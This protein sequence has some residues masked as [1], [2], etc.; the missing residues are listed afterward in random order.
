M[1]SDGT[2]GRNGRR[3]W[4]TTLLGVLTVGMGGCISPLEEPVPDDIVVPPPPTDIDGQWLELAGDNMGGQNLAGANLAGSNLA[5][6]N[7]AGVNLGGTNLASTNLASTNLAGT[8]I[9]GNNLA[10]NNLAGT[11]LASTNLAGTNLAGTNMSARTLGSSTLNGS[12]SSG[13][14]LAGNSISGTT[15]NATTLTST[16]TGRNI[17]KLG[18]AT[19]MLYSG[20]DVWSPKSA[21]CIVLGI[22][23]TAFP[24]LLAQQT[25]NAK[26]NVA[27]GMLPWGFSTKA[28]ATMALRA[29]EAIVWGDR[30]YCVFVM[31]TPM[32]ATWPGVAGFI[33][34]VFRW[35]APPSQA[36]EISG[37]EASAAADPGVSTGILGFSGMM[38]AGAQ[39]RAGTLSETAFVAGELAFAAATTNNQSVLVDFSAWV[40]KKDKNPLVLGNVQ[41]SSKPSYAE[42]LYI[43]L[44]NGDGTV[45][46]ILDDAAAKAA[47]MPTGMIDS[48]VDLNAAYLAYKDG[49]GSKPIPRRCGG[50]L[51]LN[52][53]FGEPVPPGK[54]DDG[55]AWAP[56][57]CM[58]NADDWSSVAGTTAPMN[59]YMLLNKPGQSYQRAPMV[60]GSCGTL[61]SVLSETYVHMWDRNYDLSGPCA[62]ESDAA[63]C[64]R[65]GKNCGQVTDADNCG[66]MRTV[67]NC[68]SCASPEVCGGSGQPNVCARKSTSYEGEAPGN[69]FGGQAIGSTCAEAFSKFG[70]GSSAEA[71]DGSCSGGSKVRFIGNS[72]SNYVTVN[73]VYAPVA[74]SY[75]MTVYA[76]SADTRNFYIS[77][78]GG[79][80][81]T[82]TMQS[83]GWTVQVSGSTTVTLRAGNN[84][85]KFYNNSTWAPDLDRIVVYEAGSAPPPTSPPPPTS[86]STACN[87]TISQNSYNGSDWWG[88][89]T[90]KNN[91]S[92]SVAGFKVEFDVPSNAHCTNDAVPVGAVLSPLTGSGTSAYTSGNHCVFTWNSTSLAAGASKTFNYSTSSQSFSA[93]SN[94]KAGPL[95]CQ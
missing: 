49:I 44:D 14:N 6:T 57:F 92:S 34:A 62:P 41:S 56:G 33:K 63:F 85:I 69:T 36:V 10:G 8:N 50:A 66:V 39:W 40:Q 90:V 94:V 80:G 43:A 35:N 17:H 11:N 75:A 5:G 26:I 86:G 7:L 24:K 55:L 25:A 65:L 48:V 76:Y 73:N 53:W 89:I 1:A 83:P 84:S 23:S 95:G 3:H 58:K 88:T 27:L 78:N 42:A 16:T 9:G 93:A 2:F 81:K 71:A 18:T 37:I 79:S 54:C 15:L 46:V 61:K 28:G 72:S 77:V 30:T 82:L 32:T 31:A 20:E 12:T 91:G 68:G 19:G 4:L 13:T 74:G 38:N 67:P 22:G 59:S 64:S 60:D 29:W 51:F 47:T 52:T 87:F 70:F 45:S 21:Q